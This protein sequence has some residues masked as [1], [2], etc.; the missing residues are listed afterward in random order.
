LSV[1][2][3][4]LIH[5]FGW[6]RTA[7][8]GA[9]SLGGIL[10]AIV[11][12]MIGPFL[13]RAG[14]RLLLCAAILTTGV[15]LVL[16]S[17]TNSL[18]M[19]YLLFCFARMNWASPFELGIYGAVNNWFVARR[20][21]ATSVATLAQMAGLVTMPLI[22]QLAMLRYSWRAG[23][24]AIGVLTLVVGF[25]P[26]WL[27]LVRRPE[28]VGLHPDGIARDRWRRTGQSRQ[29]P[30]RSRLSRAPRR[31][32]P[33]VLAAAFVHRAGLSDPGGDQPAY[34]AASERARHRP[35]H[36]RDDR[37]HIFADVGRGEPRLR[38]SAA[39]LAGPLS[40]GGDRR[41]PD[42][43]PLLMK[44]IASPG[45]AYFAAALFGFGVGGILTLLPIAWADYFGR[46]SFGA[47]RGVAL[48]AQVMAQ[49]VG[50]LI[51]GVLRDWTGSYQMS[52]T[53]FAALGGLSV[54]AALGANRPRAV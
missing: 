48:S 21:F 1:F 5:D 25:L 17:L 41:V 42:G 34:G 50:P 45:E 23:W 22:A 2:V 46:A 19:F 44:G 36:R 27:L 54:I 51:S 32:A 47:I 9:V 16:L 28:D 38:V 18:V 52:L 49:A 6:S 43:E 8:S 39:T 37:Q 12:P 40:D 24:L 10:A 30:S 13:D 53:V 15:A 26:T 11:S 35:G 4:P 14:S 7:L 3:T 33:G 29:Q 31:S 20:R